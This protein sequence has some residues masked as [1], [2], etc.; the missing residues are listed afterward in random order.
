MAV[1]QVVKLGVL[2][3]VHT[4][5]VAMLSPKE[6]GSSA[7]TCM[8]SISDTDV[9]ANVEFL[10]NGD[11]NYADYKADAGKGGELIPLKVFAESWL[12]VDNAKLLVCIKWVCKSGADPRRENVLTRE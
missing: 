5:F 3:T 6:L 9:A 4:T 11:E 7:A 1:R 12:H 8:V 2:A 10:E